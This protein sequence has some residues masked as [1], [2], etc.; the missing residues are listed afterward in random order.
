MTHKKDSTSIRRLFQHSKVLS[1]A[2]PIRLSIRLLS[3]HCLRANLSSTSA[4]NLFIE[5]YV[6]SISVALSS[7]L[8]F[9]AHGTWGFSIFEG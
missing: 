3:M 1:V 7:I 4:A 5:Q 2:L 8:G 9:G 6:R